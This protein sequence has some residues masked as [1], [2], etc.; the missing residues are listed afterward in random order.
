MKK[1]FIALASILAVSAW[2]T[3]CSSG[4]TDF[5][6]PP[7]TTT[8]QG[9]ETKTDT[10]ETETPETEA[11]EAETPE[12]EAPKAKKTSGSSD[13][14]TGAWDGYTFTNSWLGISI[15]FPEDCII[16]TEEQIQEVLGAGQEVLINS[17][18]ANESQTKIS[19]FTSAYDFMVN[20]PDGGSSIQLMHENVSIA[21]LGK[22][23]SAD[24][25]LSS[26]KTQLASLTDYGY[27]VGEFETV[28]LGGQTFTKMPVTAFGGAMYQ[29]YYAISNGKYVSSLIVSYLPDSAEMVEEIIS[30]ITAAE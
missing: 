3:A 30:G 25:Y 19:D 23:I 9:T 1:N 6:E 17:G 12:T 27:E 8:A 24:D 5:P 11:S 29:D 13:F 14:S 16:A 20:L 18:V 4:K 15:T 21:T 7:A 2:M 26:V 28:T 10:A 22:G